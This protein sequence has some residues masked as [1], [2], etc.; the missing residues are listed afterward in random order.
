MFVQNFLNVSSHHNI[1]LIQKYQYY[2]DKLEQHLHARYKTNVPKNVW[3]QIE[4][5][6]QKKIGK[7]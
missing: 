7:P 5:L 6:Q 1:Y 2:L 4:K 3:L